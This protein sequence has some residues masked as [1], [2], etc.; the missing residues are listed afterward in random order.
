[1]SD[2]QTSAIIKTDEA[3]RLALTYALQWNEGVSEA[4]SELPDNEIHAI[5]EQ[6]DKAFR[7][8]LKR[9]YGKQL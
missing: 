1:M 6:E 5:I 8:I 4:H 7:K 2:K 9:R 3:I